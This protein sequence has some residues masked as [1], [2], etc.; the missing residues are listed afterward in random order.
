MGQE[1]YFLWTCACKTSTRFEFVMGVTGSLR[2]NDLPSG[3]LPMNILPW[4]T[5]TVCRGKAGQNNVC[6]PPTAF[7]H[8][9]GHWTNIA[10]FR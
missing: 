8:G 9:L 4:N 1:T 7:Q 3:V 2:L 10:F 6:R 5:V